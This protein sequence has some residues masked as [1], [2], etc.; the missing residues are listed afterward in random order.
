MKKNLLLFCFLFVSILSN[1]Q[2]VI[3]EIMY[4]PPESSTD[5][6]E[7][8]EILNAGSAPYAMGGVKI[9]SGVSFT[10]PNITLGAGQVV[11]VAVDSVAI[12]IVFNENSYQWMGAL[13]NDGEALILLDAAG[14]TLDE[15]VYT[16]VPPWPA[17]VGSSLVL[18]DPTS[19]NGDPAN[20][21][22]AKNGT[23]KVINGR[24]IKGS[25]NKPNAISCE[26]VP[27]VFVDVKDFSFTPKDIT[28]NIGQTVRWS[29]K[30]GFHNVNGTQAVFPLNVESFGNGPASSEQW[31]YD[32][33]FTK[34]GKYDYQ[35]DPHSPG[36][37]GTVT[38]KS[39][40]NYLS[41]TISKATAI[42]TLGVLDSVG[43]F[44]ELKGTVHGINTRPGSLQFTLID[45]DNN[46]I[47][48]F[49]GASDLGYTVKEG[50]AI[51]IKGVLNQFNGFAQILADEIVKTGTTATVNAKVVTSLVES[52]ESSL[53]KL[54]NFTFVD[55]A[56]WKGDG[57]TFNVDVTNGTNTFV[58]RIDNDVDLAKLPAPKAPFNLTGL[59][60]Q[61]DSS[62]PFTE[63]YQLFPR[64]AADIE[65]ISNT[66]DNEL[67]KIVAFPN[68]TSNEL[69]FMHVD[70]LNEIAI[71]DLQGR[72]LK[73]VVNTNKI[74]I[75]EIQ[76]GMYIARLSLNNQYKNVKVY[77]H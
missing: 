8:I 14:A 32:F 26:V 20:W 15:V 62:E 29:N 47:G 43:K 67:A 36:M 71:F 37:R 69:T 76:N 5:S 4:N 54:N 30:G 2:L 16:S 48:V 61:F 56:A 77:K 70:N 50:D 18:C 1:A 34:A 6:L 19:N 66:V 45:A 59:L 38:V 42:N 22:I 44:A 64:Y 25:P 17:E 65:S 72:L 24:E 13:K 40:K 49:N 52:D 11:L 41:Y 23:G 7:Y 63:G 35:C 57:S 27:D 53:I 51:T 39:S 21:R 68:P 74:D 12:K 9:T 58:L 3:N 46:G 73:A 60:G 75:S 10:F 55:V 33:T 31:D 28:V